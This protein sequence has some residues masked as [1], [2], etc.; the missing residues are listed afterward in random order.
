MPW[1]RVK[2]RLKG[3]GG[4]KRAIEGTDIPPTPKIHI[5]LEHI[6]DFFYIKGEKKG[7]G[8]YSERVC[9]RRL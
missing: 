9:P 4:F 3:K 1:A 2:Q 5:I 6:V 8:Y 7:L